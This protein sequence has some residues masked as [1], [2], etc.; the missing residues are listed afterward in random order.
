MRKGYLMLG[1]VVAAMSV[2]VPASSQ[3]K[4]EFPAGFFK[5]T[6][7]AHNGKQCLEGNESGS[8]VMNGTA[9]MMNCSAATGQQWKV[10][11][12]GNGYFKLTNKFR[13]SKQEC[14]EG[15]NVGGKAKGGAAFMDKCQNVTGQMWKAVPIGNGYYKLTTKALDGTKCLEANSVGGKAMGGSSFM[16]K[17]QN[18]TGQAWKF[19]S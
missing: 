4:G 2:S 12:A 16:D 14:L 18:V 6:T 15:N 19:M 11:P 5:L 1:V 8:K 9:F 10:T 13:E 3:G 17:C 7:Q